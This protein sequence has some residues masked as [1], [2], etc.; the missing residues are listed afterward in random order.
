MNRRIVYGVGF[1]LLTIGIL[2]VS[3]TTRFGTNPEATTSPLIGTSAP[4]WSAPTIDGDAVFDTATLD[5][6]IVVVNFWAS[7]CTG[8]RVEHDALVSAAEAFAPFDV[9]FVGVLYQDNPERGGAWLEEVGRSPETIYVVDD[10]SRVGL[11][12]GVFGL[13]ETFFVD[14]AGTIV[15][16]K[17]GAIS[18]EELSAVLNQIILGETVGRLDPGEISPVG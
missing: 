1:G 4:E 3:F 11:D 18:A 12:Y 5:G 13:P 10:D 16:K 17:T 7:W 6:D 15:A 2:V 9:Q 8:C 14:R